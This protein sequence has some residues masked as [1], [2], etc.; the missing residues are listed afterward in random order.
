[1]AAFQSGQSERESAISILDGRGDE[2]IMANVRIGVEVSEDSII[3]PLVVT[4]FVSLN[5]LIFESRVDLR[6]ACLAGAGGAGF[7]SALC[8][9]LGTRRKRFSIR[10]EGRTCVGSF[11]RAIVQ[12]PQA[13]EAEKQKKT[14]NGTATRRVRR[15]D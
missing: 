12:R 9:T 6:M 2:H 7:L 15:D 5:G 3:R 1:M 8:S 11:A 13:E 4:V 14:G 10:Q